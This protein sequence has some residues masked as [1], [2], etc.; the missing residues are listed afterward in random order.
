MTSGDWF[1]LS[2]LA[3]SNSLTGFAILLSLISGYMVVAYSVGDK[4]TAL[5][6]SLANAIYLGGCITTLYAS[7]SNIRDAMMLRQKAMALADGITVGSGLSPVA[8]ASVF[9]ISQAL[10]VVGSLVFMWQVR[11]GGSD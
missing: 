2:L 6:V 9:A 11:H 4:L 8:M 1:E 10:F 5:Q 3:G 7:F